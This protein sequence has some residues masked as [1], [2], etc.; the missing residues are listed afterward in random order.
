[1]ILRL[2]SDFIPDLIVIALSLPIAPINSL[3]GFSPADRHLEM[4]LR[5]RTGV[6][7]VSLLAL[8]FF[9]SREHVALELE[10]VQGGLRKSDIDRCE[11]LNEDWLQH[12][13]NS[14]DGCYDIYIDMG[15]NIGIQIRKLYEPALFAHSQPLVAPYFDK[16]FGDAAQRRKHVCAFGFEP[17]PKHKGVLR[18]LESAYSRQGWRTRIHSETGVAAESTW[19]NF[20]PV[21]D[22]ANR[23]WGARVEGSAPCEA[24][25]AVR[26]IGVLDFL[27][28]VILPRRLPDSVGFV[29]GRSPRIVAK[30]DI[31]GGDPLVYRALVRNGLH[32]YV[33]FIYGEHI[34]ADFI[35]EY[36]AATH[37]SGCPDSTAMYLDDESCHTCDLPL[38]T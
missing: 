28:R 23:D 15:T 12:H 38:P 20:V 32:C 14:A 24:A 7:M 5:S 8:L 29:V 18:E 19:M 36:N 34:S 17:N 26:I 30:L 35:K 31:E 22:E 16:Y 4:R 3:A 1:M 25:G 13:A 6:L 11:K 33:D 10:G 9:L 21:P 27:R 2:I 37:F